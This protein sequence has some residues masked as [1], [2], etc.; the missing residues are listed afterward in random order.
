MSK[1]NIHNRQFSNIHWLAFENRDSLV[2]A[3]TDHI[4]KSLN[5]AIS[6][7]GTANF[8][9]SGGN[10]PKSLFTALSQQKLSW[11]K[12]TVFLSDERWVNTTSPDSNENLI[13]NTLLIDNAANA[14][15]IGLK[16]SDKTA[17][18]GVNNCNQALTALDSAFDIS[19]L[20][21]GTDGHT[22]S[23]FPNTAELALTVSASNPLHCNAIT[24]ID[25]P[26]ERMTLT[27][28]TLLN[29]NEII[30]LIMGDEK[31]TTFEKALNGGDQSEM[32]VRYI[33]QQPMTKVSVYWAP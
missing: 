23:L 30:L 8:I 1:S 17:A 24:P 32:P 20:G 26:Y 29:G 7:K 13:R 14:I 27:L 12:V 6:K 33:L 5:T 9:V 31:K 15:F 19:V 4:T 16:T 25:A 28:P 22:A 21:M 2:D 18:A 11:E 3:L 10:S